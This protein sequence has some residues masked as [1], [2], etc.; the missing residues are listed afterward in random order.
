MHRQSISEDYL[1]FLPS[2][3]QEQIPGQP[4]FQQQYQQPHSPPV[5]LQTNP[6]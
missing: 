3:T 6:V 2:Y 1:R 4:Q 5:E